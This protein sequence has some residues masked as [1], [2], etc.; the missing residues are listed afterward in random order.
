MGA[1]NALVAAT[2]P[3]TRVGYAMGLMQVAMGVGLG[4]GP[5]IGGFVADAFGYRTAFYITAALQAITGAVVLFAI[6]EQ[7]APH[8]PKKKQNFDFFSS[9]KILF[10]SQPIR[11]IYALRFI[12]QTARIIFIP[13]LPL[14]I[15][16]LIDNP[17]RV[18]SYT[19]IVIG[20]SS[21]ATAI[22]SVFFGR[23]GIA[24]A[25]V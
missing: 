4:L 25:I 5:V 24:G 6:N 8:P 11:L 10:A 3:C 12:N 14:F 13:I 1:T 9:W 17:D 20:A 7:S 2:V 15:I 21:A 16:T 18:N 19:G 22:F 23:M